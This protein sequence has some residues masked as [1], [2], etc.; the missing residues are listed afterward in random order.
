[1]KL[2]WCFLIS[3]CKFCCYFFHLFGHDFVEMTNFCYDMDKLTPSQRQAV[4]TLLVKDKTM[5]IFLS[6]YRPI[7][8]LQ[9][10]YKIVAKCLANRAKKVLP[11][12][13][14]RDQSCSIPGRTISNNCHLLRNV[15]DYCEMR[16]IAACILAS[17]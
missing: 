8:L 14:H 1:M 5:R 9:C 10:D 7:S 4:L 16:N 15:I 13:I 6:F 3:H 17:H 11:M 2:V 12:I